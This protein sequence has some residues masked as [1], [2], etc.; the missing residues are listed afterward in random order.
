MLGKP[1]GTQCQ[2]DD[3]ERVEI[4][5]VE[6]TVCYDVIVVTG[7]RRH[8]LSDCLHLETFRAMLLGEVSLNDY[9]MSCYAPLRTFVLISVIFFFFLPFPPADFFAAV[10]DS[11]SSPNDIACA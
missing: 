4:L 7:S 5:C 6:L 11:P 9:N 10:D 1:R 8:D 3:V 2:K